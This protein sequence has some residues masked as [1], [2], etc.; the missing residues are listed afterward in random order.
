MSGKYIGVQALVR[1]DFPKPIYVHCAADSL[2]IAVSN[3]SNIKPIRNCVEIIKMYDFLN[4]LKYHNILIKY[5]EKSN[6]HP[7]ANTLK[8]FCVIR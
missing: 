4:T 1:R 2:N 7:K 6:E 5:I 8:I 3:L